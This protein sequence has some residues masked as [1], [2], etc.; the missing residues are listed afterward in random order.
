MKLTS[1]VLAA[2]P[3]GAT[4]STNTFPLSSSFNTN[5]N[6]LFNSTTRSLTPAD[7]DCLANRIKS[8]SSAIFRAE[9]EV[10]VI[11]DFELDGDVIGNDACIELLVMV[12]VGAKAWAT[13]TIDVSVRKMIETAFIV[14]IV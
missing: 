4:V 6:G 12:F 9:D 5:P 2:L 14:L 3:L 10:D 11:V 1:P 8:S 13:F 7:R